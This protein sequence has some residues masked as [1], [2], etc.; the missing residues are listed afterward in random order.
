MSSGVAVN[1]KCVD[2]FNKV[3]KNREHRA[4]VLKINDEMTEVQ[5]DNTHPPS[6][7]NP[8]KSWEQ[9]RKTLPDSDCRYII[10]DFN[11]EHQGAVKNR[12]IF[13]LWSPETS[14]IRS[15]M[16]Y[17]S[18]QEGVVT[19]LEGIQ[20][21]IQCTDDD[22]LKFEVLAKKLAAHTASY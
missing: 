20:R 22:D 19:K 13:L 2:S 12:L 15:K 14:K 10:Y 18:S 4:I 6:D 16:I 17:A 21:Q 1:R 3:I 5:V 11:Y 8:Q 7:D 9:F